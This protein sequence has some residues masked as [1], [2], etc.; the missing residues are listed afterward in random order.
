MDIEHWPQMTNS[1]AQAR[2]IGSGPCGQAAKSSSNSRVC[3]GFAGR[4]QNY[5][6]AALCLGNHLPGM[7][8][9]AATPWSDTQT[10]R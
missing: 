5:S 7:P 6:P 8:P 10:W 1:T 2:R 3:R 4:S 9:Q